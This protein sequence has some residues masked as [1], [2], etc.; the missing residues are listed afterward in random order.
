MRPEQ[1]AMI[2]TV[3]WRFAMALESDFTER[4]ANMH[5]ERPQWTFG[6]ALSIHSGR[7]M[8]R[9]WKQSVISDSIT[10]LWLMGL[11]K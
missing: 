2:Y 8:R 1:F 4:R 7:P 11:L 10:Q 5:V 6:D 9:A 3:A